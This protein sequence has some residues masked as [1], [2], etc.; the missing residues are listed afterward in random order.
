ML[1][2]PWV[3]FMKKHKHESKFYK[4]AKFYS[5]NEVILHMENAH[6]KYFQFRQTLFNPLNELKHIDTVKEGYGEGSFIVVKGV[7]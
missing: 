7:K 4:Y 1:K 5:V 6:F 2:V 3:S